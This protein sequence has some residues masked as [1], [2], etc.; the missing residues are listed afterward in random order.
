[1]AD[2]IEKRAKGRF[3]AHPADPSQ[4]P[5]VVLFRFSNSDSSSQLK[6]PPHMAGGIWQMAN[7]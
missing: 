4:L 3:P 2:G 6:L 5:I 7:G 1:M